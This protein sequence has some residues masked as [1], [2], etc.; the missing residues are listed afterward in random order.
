MRSRAGTTMY[1]VL[2]L[3]GPCYSAHNNGKQD[4]IGYA[5]HTVSQCFL[6]HA[7]YGL[8]ELKYVTTQHRT[9]HTRAI[10][11]DVE[12]N[13]SAWAK[14][15]ARESLLTRVLR[16]VCGGG[17]PAYACTRS[18]YAHIQST[19]R[20]GMSAQPEAAESPCLLIISHTR[21][22]VQLLWQA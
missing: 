1:A 22:C 4:W 19:M 12:S 15:L 18:E 20:R 14:V 21:T 13:A 6:L 9:S 3:Q 7:S 11:G 2:R 17:S 10:T 16:S 8:V 5:V